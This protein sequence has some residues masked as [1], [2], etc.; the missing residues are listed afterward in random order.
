MQQDRPAPVLDRRDRHVGHNR[1][2][3]GRKRRRF[4]HD[5]PKHALNRQFDV[6]E[7]LIADVGVLVAVCTT[8]M[9]DFS[10]P[11]RRNNA[12]IDLELRLLPTERQDPGSAAGHKRHAKIVERHH[13]LCGPLSPTNVTGQG[14]PG[15]R[16]TAI[17]C[18]CVQWHRQ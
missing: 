14:V 11:F 8:V 13:H 15:K 12:R 5:L 2:R 7:T 18:E 1:P 10:R 9:P 4:R 16:R 17:K 3:I 6:V